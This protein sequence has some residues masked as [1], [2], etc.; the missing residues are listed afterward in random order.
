MAYRAYSSRAFSYRTLCGALAL[1]GAVLAPAPTAVRAE[2]AKETGSKAETAAVERPSLPSEIPAPAAAPRAAQIEP[3]MVE[4]VKRVQPKTPE[5]KL[6]EKK[7]AI[8]VTIEK[9]PALDTKKSS[10]NKKSCGA[11]QK[12]SGN[13]CVRVAS[14]KTSGKKKR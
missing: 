9:D 14:N 12:R 2:P 4:P 6:P 8:V 1:V 10:D 5:I 11:G 7:A 13:G 3:V